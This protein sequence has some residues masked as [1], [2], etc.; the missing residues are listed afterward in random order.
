[1][2][3]SQ[4]ASPSPT[5]IRA[6]TYRA[7]AGLLQ[8][9]RAFFAERNCLEVETPLLH[10]W[11][12]VEAHLDSFSVTRAGVRKS[13]EMA[14]P[15]PGERAGYL[16]TS[17]EYA[18]K[19]LLAEL[20]VDLFQI[21]HCFRE[22]DAGA[23]HREEFLMLEWYRIG[24]DEFRLMDE[25]EALVRRA[26]AAP[27]ARRRLQ[28]AAP[29]TRR[30]VAE[31]LA[32]H[33]GCTAERESLGAAL[34]QRGLIGPG[35][36][37][38]ETLRYDELFFS[39]FLNLVEPALDFADPVFVYDYPAPLAALARVEG[40][41]ARRFELYWR[42]LELANGYYELTDPAEHAA[43]FVSENRLRRSLG[44]AEMTP[45]PRLVAALDRGLP[46][47]SGVALGLDRLL[48]SLLDEPS[49]PELGL[50]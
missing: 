30:S 10:P 29:F 46:E 7:R 2:P 6:E 12:A 17:P 47:S 4:P 48:L 15:A 24:Q 28:S 16:I 3:E 13:V 14:P 34:R 32:E 5:L 27:W 44:K 39:V 49:L 40:G 33:A 20:R 8:T 50:L 19:I 1:M 43:R 37:A 35:G 38:P 21:A 25:V 11:G 22:G 31:L 41:C 42:R 26:G 23:N 9:V 45:D 36:E 18:L